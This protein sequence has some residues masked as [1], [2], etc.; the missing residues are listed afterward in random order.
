MAGGGG[1]GGVVAHSVCGSVLAVFRY[2]VPEVLIEVYLWLVQ[3]H[4]GY[5][6]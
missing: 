2:S 3:L 4:M 6:D 5:A 1:G